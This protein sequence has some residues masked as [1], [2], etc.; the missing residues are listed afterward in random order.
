MNSFSAES[1]ISSIANPTNSNLSNENQ[2]FASYVQLFNKIP[3]NLNQ[4]LKE[5]D[6]EKLKKVKNK[7]LNLHFK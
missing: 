2:M 4:K 5:K 1:S 7:I 6:R 3:K